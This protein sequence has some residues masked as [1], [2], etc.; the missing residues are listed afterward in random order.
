[1]SAQREAFLKDNAGEAISMTR[2]TRLFPS[3]MLA[4]A[5]LES[6]DGLSSLAAKYNNYFGIKADSSWTGESVVLPTREVINGKSVMMDEPFRVYADKK[7]SFRDRIKFLQRFKR[8]K[9]VFQ[10]TTPQAQAEALQKAGYA[11]AT[12][13]S[14]T[15]KDIIEK[16]DLEKYDKRQEAQNFA[17]ISLATSFIIG[18]LYL[19]WRK[20][21]FKKIL[22]GI[23]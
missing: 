2:W 16:Y 15:I 11:T 12:D 8:Y 1:M 13:Y 7:G 17:M 3:V 19:G 20:G 21:I 4:Q 9:I 6:G 18:L 5:A 10:A 23:F 14:K 22:G